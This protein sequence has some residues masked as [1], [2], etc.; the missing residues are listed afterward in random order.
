MVNILGVSVPTNSNNLF[1]IQIKMK[2]DLNFT[3]KVLRNGFILSGIM[4]AS[5]FATGTL[6]YELLKPILVFFIGYFFTELGRHY[7]ITPHNKKAKSTTFI[8][9]GM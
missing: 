5:T 4:F 8:F 1:R 9:N 7:K 6:S 2:Q 3:L